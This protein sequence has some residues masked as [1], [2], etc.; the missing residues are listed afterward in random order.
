MK[1]RCA[2]VRDVFPPPGRAPSRN[3]S[4]Q[5]SMRLSSIGVR[6]RSATPRSRVCHRAGLRC[7]QDAPHAGLVSRVLD[8]GAG[9]GPAAVQSAKSCVVGVLR[10]GL[11]ARRRARDGLRVRRSRQELRR[12]AESGISVNAVLR[13]SSCASVP[14]SHTRR[15]S[16]TPTKILATRKFSCRRGWCANGADAFG[17]EVEAICAAVQRPGPLGARGHRVAR[18]AARKSLQNWRS[19][20]RSERVD[21][22]GARSDLGRKARTGCLERYARTARG[23]SN[24]KVRRCPVDVLDPQHRGKDDARRV[25]AAAATRRCRSPARLAGAGDLSLRRSRYPRKD[26]DADSAA[27]GGRTPSP[28]S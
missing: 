25:P 17:T 28:P 4:A 27:G 20:S 5:A 1:S 26:G 24:R 13:Q 23:G 22:R 7:D 15:P 19:D 12:I 9:P 10:T 21:R 11:H 3:A 6:R 8:A 2:V 16:K 14:R 18:I